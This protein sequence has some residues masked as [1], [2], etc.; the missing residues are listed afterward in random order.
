MQEPSYLSKMILVSKWY[1]AGIDPRNDLGIQILWSS[2][3]HQV[4]VY[5][6]YYNV[7]THQVGFLDTI[8]DIMYSYHAFTYITLQHWRKPLT[9]PDDNLG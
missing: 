7:D 6:R 5:D 2:D 3:T 1:Q 4:S 8:I 9:F